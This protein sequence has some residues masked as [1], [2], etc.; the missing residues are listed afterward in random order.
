MNDYELVFVVHPELDEN[1][2]KELLEKVKG[3]IAEAGGQVTKVDLWGKRRLAYI[4]RKQREGVYVVMQASM[5][6]ASCTTLERNL[7]FQE[8][9]LRFLLTQK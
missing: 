1:A 2:F 7:R 3:W 9:V 6:P 5:A 8:P 4:I